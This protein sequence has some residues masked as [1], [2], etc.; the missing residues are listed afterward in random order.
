MDIGEAQASRTARGQ[1]VL[2][3]S[4]VTGARTC[5]AQHYAPPLRETDPLR[6]FGAKPGHSPE[7]GLFG[8]VASL[9]VRVMP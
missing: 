6:D 8:G 4:D 1:R 5:S 3:H 9:A 2:R 7:H